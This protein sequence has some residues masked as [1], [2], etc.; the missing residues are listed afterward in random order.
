V[1]N[2]LTYYTTVK[3]L[4][5]PDLRAIRLPAPPLSEQHDIAAFLDRETAKID[6]LI[7]DQRRFI[8]LLEEKRQ[9]VITTAV[10]KGLMRGIP[11]KSSHVEWLGEVPADWHIRR[12]KEVLCEVDDRSDDG[13]EELLSVS[14]LTGVTPRKEKTV[15]MF[16]AETKEG[17]KRCQA[18]DLVVNTMWAWMGALGVSPCPGIVSPSYN[19]YRARRTDVID[20]HFLDLLC[21]I[22]PLVS[23]IKSVSTGVWTS[24]L[25]LYPETL[26]DIRFAVP[27]MAEQRAIVARIEKETSSL[28]RTNEA[29]AA[30]I[31][32]LEEHRSSLITDAVTGKID[33]RGTTGALETPLEAAQ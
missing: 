2:D 23:F 1:L 22:P 32:L 18:G 30:A 5:T 13:S 20:T 8:D 21:R 17:Y 3:H 31:S 12:F 11:M 24:R 6:V 29:A 25:R 9:A 7:D 27:P 14:H 4:S 26:F 15:Y 19:V 10:T 33:V 16:E 28:R